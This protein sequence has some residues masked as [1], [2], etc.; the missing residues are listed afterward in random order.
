[1]SFT[2]RLHSSIGLSPV[3]L[4]VISLVDSVLRALAISMFMFSV[5]GI[6]RCFASGWY[7]GISHS[8]L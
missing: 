6:R 5:V 8:I 2:F 4:L 3:S 7:L 1:M